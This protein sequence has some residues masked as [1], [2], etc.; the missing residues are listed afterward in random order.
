VTTPRS[1]SATLLSCVDAFNKRD[2][3]AA[4]A[5]ADDRA[6]FEIPMLKPNRLHGRDEISRGIEAAFKELKSVE[7]T[8]AKPAE[9][10]SVAITEGRLKVTR[11][12][13]PDEDHQVGIVA[14]V[15]G[16]QLVRFSLYLHARNRRLWSDET[17]L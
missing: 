16:D 2:A 17:I 12:S 7:L 11:N 6:L 8:V 1:P 14:E 9:T 5:M 15:H 4:A 3:S 13:A 10:D